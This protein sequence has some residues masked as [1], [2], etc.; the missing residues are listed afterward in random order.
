VK[1]SDPENK[2]KTFLSKT[3]TGLIILLLLIPI[4]FTLYSFTYQEK[5]KVGIVLTNEAFIE[6]GVI[7]QKGLNQFK[8]IFDAQIL[9]ELFNESMVRIKDNKYLTDDYFVAKFAKTMR[10]KYKV[11]IVMI[12]TNRTINNWLGDRQAIWGQA[13]T[14]NAM[15]LVT[16]VYFLENASEHKKYIEHT[17]VHEALHLLGYEH[18]KDSRSCIM[19]YASLEMTLNDEYSLELPYRKVLWSISTGFEFNQA[20]FLIKIFISLMLAPIFI[21]AIIIAH[22]LFKKYIYRTEKINPNPVI[23]GFGI[24][25]I[26]FL[27]VSAFTSTLYPRLVMF[28]SS[29]FIYVIIEVIYFESQSKSKK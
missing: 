11:N 7:A 19:K 21:A 4:L 9:D 6:D 22:I 2:G 28:I 29:V 23:F 10:N 1:N 18:P 27:L 24:F 17:S 15:T 16:T 13:D 20:I 26:N 5:I 14:K 3:I 8:G 12:L 25:F